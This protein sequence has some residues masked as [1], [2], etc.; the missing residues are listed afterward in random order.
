MPYEIPRKRGKNEQKQTSTGSQEKWGVHC[1]FIGCRVPDFVAS[2]GKGGVEVI[3]ADENARL[4]QKMMGLLY[5]VK[6][7]TINYHLKKVFAD[8]ELDEVSVI[9]IFE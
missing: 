5:D 7:H 8:S 2:S 4:T 3:Y 1:P 6:T 9:R